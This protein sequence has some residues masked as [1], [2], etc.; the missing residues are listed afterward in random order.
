MNLENAAV[1]ATCDAGGLAA[2]VLADL[3]KMF[4]TAQ[5]TM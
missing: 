3:G 4:T 2:G 5:D 1:P